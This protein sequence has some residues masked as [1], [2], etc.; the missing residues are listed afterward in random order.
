MLD[1]N[2]PWPEPLP[3][4]QGSGPLKG[5]YRI[6]GTWHAS[7]GGLLFQV[8]VV[9]GFNEVYLVHPQYPQHPGFKLISDHQGTGA[10]TLTPGWRAE[11]PGN[12]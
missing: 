9:P 10:W 4:A 5:L 12:A 7:L 6:N 11:C 3:T 8:N 2:V 1:I